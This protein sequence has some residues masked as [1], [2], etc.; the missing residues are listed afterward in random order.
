MNIDRKVVE[1]ALAALEMY[2]NM[3][4]MDESYLLEIDL[5]P[6][7]ITALRQALEQPAPAQRTWA[8]LT[9]EEI[10]DLSYDENK[11]C[12]VCDD[13]DAVLTFARAIE[14]KLKEKNT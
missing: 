13:N 7:A 8:E 2:L 12:I 1:Q 9:D 6:K 5:A 11:F 14:A 3:D 4:T 10:L